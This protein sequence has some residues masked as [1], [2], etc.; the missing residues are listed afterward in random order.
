MHVVASGGDGG[1]GGDLGHFEEGVSL[2]AFV[3]EDLPNIVA[4]QLM[5][6]LPVLRT[7]IFLDQH[8]HLLLTKL[9]PGQLEGPLEIVGVHVSLAQLVE[10]SEEFVDP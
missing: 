7:G 3:G 9:Y 2:D 5:L 1:G 10:V 6:N 4:E 8:V